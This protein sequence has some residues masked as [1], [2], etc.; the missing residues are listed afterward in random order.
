MENDAICN[1][2]VSSVVITIIEE[3]TDLDA[4]IDEQNNIII[5]NDNGFSGVNFL[6]YS[7]LITDNEGTQYSSEADV[8]IYAD[9][10]ELKNDNF[11]SPSLSGD[12][13]LLEIFDNDVYCELDLETL[14]FTAPANGVIST[15]ATGDW[16]AIYYTPNE[17]YFGDDTFTYSICDAAI[18]SC[19]Q[20]TVTLSIPATTDCPDFNLVADEI[21][22]LLSSLGDLKSFQLDIYANDVICNADIST[23]TFPVGA[24]SGRVSLERNTEVHYTPNDGFVGEDSFEYT[25]CEYGNTQNCK[26]VKVNLTVK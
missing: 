10:I 13:Y 9:G 21:E 14:E 11:D 15:E 8:T 12:K 25:L 4:I 7:L 6:T 16:I 17:G 24:T 23:V 19:G 3:P 22:L 26:T 18:G 1:E 2:Y 5:T 20:A